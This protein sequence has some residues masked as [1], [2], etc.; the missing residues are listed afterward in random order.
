MAVSEKNDV[1][2]R[3]EARGWQGGRKYFEG[4]VESGWDTRSGKEEK[5]KG[6]TLRFL[7]WLGNET[8]DRRSNPGAPPRDQSHDYAE[9][10]KTPPTHRN[11]K[12]EWQRKAF[13]VRP[14]TWNCSNE[15]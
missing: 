14:L 3:K 12:R 5:T 6:L 7:N 10:G 9:A 15:S 8:I 4:I 1:K 13:V 2:R 11:I